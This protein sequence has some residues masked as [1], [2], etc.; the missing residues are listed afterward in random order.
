MSTDFIVFN[1][2]PT[3]YG[4]KVGNLVAQ[5]YDSEAELTEFIDTQDRLLRSKGV[6]VVLVKLTKKTALIYVYRVKQLASLLSR[7]SVQQFLAKF[8]YMDFSV[9]GCLNHLKSRLTQADFPHEIGVFLGY[10]L[11]DIQ[12]FIDKKGADCPCVGIWKAYNN[13]DRAKLIF[14][15]YSKCTASCC[16]RYENGTDIYRLTAAG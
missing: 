16:R 7:T 12:C 14:D 1:C 15:L 6:H 9:N 3:L 11:D 4:V 13:I 8:G 10:P 5:Q 2:A